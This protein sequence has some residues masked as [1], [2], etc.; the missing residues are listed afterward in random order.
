MSDSDNLGKILASPDVEI[1]RIFV[2]TAERNIERR[3]ITNR[4][5]FAVIASVFVAY[6]FLVVGVP[7]RGV[8]DEGGALHGGRPEGRP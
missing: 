1:Y 7:G 3:L 2:D 6:A 5:F 4:C 8:G